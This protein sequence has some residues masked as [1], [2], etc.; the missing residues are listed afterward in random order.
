MVPKWEILKKI[1]TTVA[2]CIFQRRSET[3]ILLL[4]VGIIENF[5]NSL[6]NSCILIDIL[7]YPQQSCIRIL[8]S[9]DRI[10]YIITV[11]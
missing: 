8:L 4:F 9:F 5:K 11:R 10:L 1:Y 7:P 6:Y 2:N 3:L